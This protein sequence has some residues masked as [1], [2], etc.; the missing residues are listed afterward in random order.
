VLALGVSWVL[1]RFWHTQQG[2]VRT[3]QGE[4]GAASLGD[5]LGSGKVNK[6]D[7]YGREREPTFPFWNVGCG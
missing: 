1:G 5:G 2:E 7:A 6:G 3:K 4:E